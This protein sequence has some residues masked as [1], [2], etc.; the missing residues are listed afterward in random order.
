[1]ISAYAMYFATCYG[2]YM[3]VTAALVPA[4]R[5]RL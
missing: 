3:I 2:Y 4:A 5:A 1:M